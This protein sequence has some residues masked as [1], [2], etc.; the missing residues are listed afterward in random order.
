MTATL[1]NKRNLPMTSLNALVEIE[2]FKDA[3]IA[4][5]QQDCAR[6]CDFISCVFTAQE[7]KVKEGATPDEVRQATLEVTDY[8]RHACDIEYELTGD[9]DLTSAIAQQLGVD[10]DDLAPVELPKR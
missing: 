4:E 8:L 9:T 7:R 6:M 10:E 5:L 2:T 1:K 3:S